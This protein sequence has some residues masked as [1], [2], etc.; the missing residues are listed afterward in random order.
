MTGETTTPDLAGMSA[1]LERLAADLMSDG[2]CDC[3]QM[4]ELGLDRLGVPEARGGSGG[5]VGDLVTLVSAFGRQGAL[6]PLVDAAVSTH[7]MASSGLG[8]GFG[9]L[10]RRDRRG[11]QGPHDGE[12][13]TGGG[14]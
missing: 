5:S 13:R 10:A 11:R 2:V 14:P 12:R 6:S 4:R 3:S 1:D 7:V 9:V 8:E